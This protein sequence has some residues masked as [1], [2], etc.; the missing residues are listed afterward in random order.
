MLSSISPSYFGEQ[1]LRSIGLAVTNDILVRLRRGNNRQHPQERKKI[2]IDDSRKLA[3]G[4]CAVHLL[5]VS[6]SVLILAINLRQVFIGI[7]F[8]SA[9]RSETVNLALLQTAAK[10][11]ELLIVASLAAVTFQFLR[12]ELLYGDG[13]PLGLLAAG[14]E[15]TKLSFLWSPETLGTLMDTFTRARTIRRFALL[16]FVLIAGALATLAGPA[17]AVLLIPNSQDW[18]AGTRHVLLR[19]TQEQIWPATLTGNGTDISE[20][21]SSTDA[22]RYGICPSGGYYSL[23]AHYGQT[24]VNDYESVVPNYAKRLSGNHYYWPLNSAPPIST[25]IIS[26]GILGSKSSTFIQP[27]I[28]VAVVLDRLMEGWWDKLQS[29]RGFIEENVDDRAAVAHVLSAMTTVT[30]SMAHNLSRSDRTIAFPDTDSSD[31][32]IDRSISQNLGN[33]EPSEHARFSWL[34]PI[35]GDDWTSTSAIFQSPWTSDNQSRLAVGCNVQAQWVPSQVLTDA[36]SF[37]QGWYPKNI[38]FGEA[39]P[40]IGHAA[41]D[42]STAYS[43]RNAIAVDKDWLSMLTPPI[44]KGQPGYQD[45]APTTIEG[46]LGSVP[47]MDGLQA[48]DGRSLVDAWNEGPES[49]RKLL[50]SIIGSV[51]SDGLARVDIENV[52][53]QAGSPSAWAPLDPVSPSTSHRPS[54]GPF[55]RATADTNN[56]NEIRVDFSISGF[57]YRLTLVQKLAMVVLLVHILIATAHITWLLWKHESSSCWDSIIELLVLAQNSQPAF[58]ALGNTAAGIKDS[59]NF[60]TRVV[61]RATKSPGGTEAD[62]LEMIYP[63]QADDNQDNEMINLESNQSYPGVPQPEGR[64]ISHPS[65]WPLRRHHSQTSA[66]E[67]LDQQPVYIETDHGTPLIGKITA[68]D[69]GAQ[70]TE[71]VQVGRAY[72]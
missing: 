22:I 32:S 6:V 29:E 5:P 55:R 43:K 9:I 36:Y 13:L 59:R 61:I 57:S 38:S 17:C 51:F 60:A 26:L 11:Q 52:F 19:G 42:E 2:A 58:S 72:G 63:A 25:S 14:F 10:L 62:H 49:R 23:W 15:F 7:D 53:D 65:T 46:I 40:S 56:M 44:G 67:S 18:P 45:W 20:I 69:L 50:T 30:C 48:G 33:D 3:I 8:E 1:F 24:N 39:I 64:R 37:W 70:S 28:G 4:R 47:L 12:Y 54:K 41:I 71:K 66:N 21:C 68:T 16:L 27:K 31:S 34:P 35:D